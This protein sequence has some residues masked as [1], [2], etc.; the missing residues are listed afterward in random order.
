MFLT[1]A[2]EQLPWVLSAQRQHR[3]LQEER[4]T[5]TD[6]PDVGIGHPPPHL[7][8]SRVRQRVH[9]AIGRRVLG[10]HL[11]LDKSLTLEPGEFV[12]GQT[13]HRITEPW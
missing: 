3:D 9:L 12:L 7:G 2:V 1:L 8:S 13:R 11:A 6:R 4:I 5:Q 10:D